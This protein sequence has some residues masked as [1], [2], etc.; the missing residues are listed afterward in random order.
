MYSSG[1]QLIMEPPH[2]NII[3]SSNYFLNYSLL[4]EDRWEVFKINEKQQLETLTPSSIKQE[5]QKQLE[6]FLIK[7]LL[8]KS[9]Q[10]KILRQRQRE[11]K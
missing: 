9:L 10:Q 1:N 8:K 11:E 6:E 4:S 7:K 5:L 2:I 3:I